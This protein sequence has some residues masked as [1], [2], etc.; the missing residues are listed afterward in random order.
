[1]TGRLDVR[2]TRRATREIGEAAAWWHANRPAAPLAFAE[3]LERAFDLLSAYPRLGTQARSSR[4]AGVR[5]IHLAR[6]RYDLYY[7][8]DASSVVIVALWHSSRGA[9]PAL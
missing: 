7:R 8:A 1:L 6:L 3:E 2:V 5:R 9:S 4:L